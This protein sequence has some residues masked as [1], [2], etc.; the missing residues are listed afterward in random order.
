MLNTRHCNLKPRDIIERIKQTKKKKN[1][2]V[3]L[4]L[5]K[6]LTVSKFR[7]YNCEVDNYVSLHCIRFSLH[8]QICEINITELT[9]TACIL[10]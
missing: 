9:E 5:F 1:P 6:T 2:K 8:L 7:P 10:R 4:R 3:T